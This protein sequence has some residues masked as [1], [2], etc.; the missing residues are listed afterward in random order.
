MAEEGVLHY[1][2]AVLTTFDEAKLDPS[3]WEE[4]LSKISADEL[5]KL[6]Q[7][8]QQEQQAQQGVGTRDD[9]EAIAEGEEGEEEEDDTLAEGDEREEEEEVDEDDDTFE[10][11]PAV[12]EA[13]FRQEPVAP[14]GSWGSVF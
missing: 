5:A 9:V 7:V 3:R 11:E 14:V 10:M 8:V 1:Q 13:P 6:A 2:V 4:A 12:S